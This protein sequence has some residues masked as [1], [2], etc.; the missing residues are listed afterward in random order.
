MK[1]FSQENV[2]EIS[3]NFTKLSLNLS[4]IQGKID[5]VKKLLSKTNKEL[6]ENMTDRKEYQSLISN[7]NQYQITIKNKNDSINFIKKELISLN[8]KYLNA[9]DITEKDKIK[10]ELDAKNQEKTNLNIE[11]AK[12]NQKKE[13][14]EIQYQIAI[15]KIELKIY[16][17]N[18]SKLNLTNLISD[19]TNQK[20]A[21]N[22][23]IRNLFLQHNTI[24]SQIF[25]SLNKQNTLYSD[26]INK[27]NDRVSQMKGKLDIY[28]E[29]KFFFDELGLYFGI[30]IPYNFSKYYGQY[31]IFQKND[32][33]YINMSKTSRVH[34]EAILNLRVPLKK[35][36]YSFMIGCN[37]FDNYS[38]RV[39]DGANV[40]V[41]FRPSK[42]VPFEIEI[43]Y[44][45]SLINKIIPGLKD[46]NGKELSSSEAVDYLKDNYIYASNGNDINKYVEKDFSHSICVSFLIPLDIVNGIKE[47]FKNVK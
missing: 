15:K 5:S 11:L 31:E 45:I 18:N 44:K 34:P 38:S 30:A 21:I 36:K 28:E 42:K 7:L 6:E 46:R 33:N 1:A 3:K 40:G 26:S 39:L 25:L 9:T 17:I 4:K 13:T 47:T 37:L 35:E 16:E 19:L 29:R 27:L 23:E 8:E 32:S 20:E 12:I 14:E 2:E 24:T 43:S 10:N 41:A 22:N